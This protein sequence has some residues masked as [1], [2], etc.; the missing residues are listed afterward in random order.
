MLRARRKEQLK[1]QLE[2]LGARETPTAEKMFGALEAPTQEP[3]GI[4]MYCEEERD[5]AASLDML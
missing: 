5:A 4:D 2:M 3:I 1:G